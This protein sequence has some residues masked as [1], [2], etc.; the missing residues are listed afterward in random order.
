[1]TFSYLLAGK[2]HAQL[3]WAWKRFYNLGA[4]LKINSHSGNDLNNAERG[5]IVSEEQLHINTENAYKV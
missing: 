3:S 2:F 4:R 1:M 5:L